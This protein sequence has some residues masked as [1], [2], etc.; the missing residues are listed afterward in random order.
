MPIGQPAGL[1]ACRWLMD[2]M[3]RGALRTTP[4][5]APVPWIA[6]RWFLAGHRSLITK[7]GVPRSCEGLGNGAG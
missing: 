7:A 6:P 3:H 4:G 5:Q 1:V 2:W